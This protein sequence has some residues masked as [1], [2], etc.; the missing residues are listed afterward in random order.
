MKFAYLL[1]SCN[2]DDYF[3][4]RLYILWCL[5][6]MSVRFRVGGCEVWVWVLFFGV[7]IL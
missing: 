2:K 3:V 6:V 7:Y 5:V 4:R 1:F